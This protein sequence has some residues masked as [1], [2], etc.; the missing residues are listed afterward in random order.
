MLSVKS[1]L[2]F[3]SKFVWNISHSKKNSARYYQKC[4]YVF[5]QSAS[6]SCQILIKLEFS[7]QVFEKKILKYQ[8][9]WKSIN[10]EPNGSRRT[11]RPID[12]RAYVQIWRRKQSFFPIL[13]TSIKVVIL[14]PARKW[15]IFW[16]RVGKIQNSDKWC[17]VTFTWSQSYVVFALFSR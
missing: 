4:T 11:D 17:D 5:M 8:I 7:R 3:P 12:T 15:N 9:S 1:F 14:D 10:Y 2:I 13:R 6:Y 16:S